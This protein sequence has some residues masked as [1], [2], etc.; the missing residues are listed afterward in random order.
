MSLWT[1]VTWLG[2]ATLLASVSLRAL[3]ALRHVVA[4]QV[5]V[6]SVGRMIRLAVVTVRAWMVLWG[7]MA[8][9]DLRAS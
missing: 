4:L 2:R 8:S 1:P 3:W 6:A 5:R 7:L 9:L